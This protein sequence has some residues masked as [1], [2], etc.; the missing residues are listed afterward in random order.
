MRLSVF[1]KIDS[2]VELLEKNQD[3]YRRLETTLKATLY[4][5]FA[6][7]SD[8]IIDIFSRI[9]SCESL[10]EKIIRNRL[11]LRY[12]SSE[13]ILDNLSDLI[14]VSIECRFIEEENKVLMRLREFFNQKN[15]NDGYYYSDRIP[16][17]FLDVQSKQPQVQKNGF[18]IY[19]ID[20]YILDKDM[21]INF[22]LQIKALV[23]AFWGDIEHKLVY[24]NTNYYVYD[25][26][27]K[28]ILSS[29]KANLTIID[30]QLSIV[31]NQI[32]NASSNDVSI[33]ETTFEKMI[34]KAINDIFASKMNDSIG[35]TI[36]LKNISALLGH[37]I[38]IKDIRYTR[39]GNEKL[40]ALFK[41]FKKINNSTI[42]FE[43]EIF[44][45]GEFTSP[46]IFIDK[47]GKYL[48]SII[49]DDYE[50][51]VFFKMLFFVEPGNNAEDFALFLNVYKNYLIDDYWIKTSFVRLNMEDSQKIQNAC[52]EMLADA[53]IQ[54]G[55]IKIITDS[56]MV[57]INH[58]FIRF[59]N[60][61]EER[62]INFEDFKHYQNAYK[63]DLCD[64]IQAIFI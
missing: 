20:G 7:D 23:H 21:K 25:E 56:K 36:N 53:L 58:E 63:D 8:M 50:W 51:Y 43:H 4:N 22:E 35:F 9:K 60:E 2:T 27:M 17:L 10:R 11:Y 28:D 15:Q 48:I 29:I 46:D 32:Q 45:E 1:D 38:F 31:Y 6:D 40:M 64:R 54:I 42:D 18:S 52:M 26:F 30:R 12:E 24:K 41:T 16:Y 37:Y 33:S 39:G 61:L 5:I 34:T 62:V 13:A 44:F 59:I 3:T 14:G 19:R 47:L 57:Q 55:S 49:N